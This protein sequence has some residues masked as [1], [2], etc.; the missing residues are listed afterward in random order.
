MLIRHQGGNRAEGFDGMHRRG[1]IR[2]RAEQQRRREEGAGG[3]K[4]GLAAEQNFAPGLNQRVDIVLYIL[5]LLLA[6][7]RAHFT[8]SCA[9]SPTVTFCRRAISASLTA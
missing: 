8:P 4:I 9:G 1:F 3:V 5:A 7:Q 6:D 2:L